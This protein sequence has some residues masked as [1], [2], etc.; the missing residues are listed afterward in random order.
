MNSQIIYLE[1]QAF[2]GKKIQ[3]EL[4]QKLNEM[5]IK[6]KFQAEKLEE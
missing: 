4:L 2:E 1:E 3:V 5:K 6:N